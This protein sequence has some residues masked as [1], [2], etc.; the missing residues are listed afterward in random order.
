MFCNLS[1]GKHFNIVKD[2][3]GG[4]GYTYAP[5]IIPTGNMNHCRDQKHCMLAELNVNIFLNSYHGHI[6][7]S[8]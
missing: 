8:K 6:L 3:S 4:G 7:F 1:L 2:M 5:V